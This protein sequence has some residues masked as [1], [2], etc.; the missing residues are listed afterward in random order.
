MVY[1]SKID[2]IF[3][4]LS[5]EINQGFYN[6]KQRFTSVRELAKKCD[7]SVNSANKVLQS[8]EDVGLLTSYPKRGFFVKAQTLQKP[9]FTNQAK[10]IT[11]QPLFCLNEHIKN[12]SESIRS[13]VDNVNH[14]GR[15]RLDLAT[16][17]PDFYPTAKLQTIHNRVARKNP[18]VFT[19][20]AFGV[21]LPELCSQVS[22]QYAKSGC[23]L[24]SSEIVITHGA[25]QALLLAL[26]AT[27][28][29]G[30]WIL[31]EAPTYFGFLQILDTL[32]LNAVELPIDADV[33]LKSESLRSVIEITKKSGKQIRACLVQANHHNPTGLSISL[34]DRAELLKICAD[35]EIAVI[36]DDTFGELHNDSMLYRL[37]PLKALDVIGNVI[38]CS[39]LSKLIAPGLRVGFISGGQWHER[40]KTLQHSISIS[41][42]LLPQKVIAEFMKKSYSLYLKNLRAAC[43]VNIEIAFKIIKNHFPKDTLV[44]KPTGGYLLWVTLPDKVN[45]DLLFHMAL[46]KHG[47]A[48]APGALFS[49]FIGH[50]QSL[51]IN[52]A[53]MSR[54]GEQDGLKKLGALAREMMSD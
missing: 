37:P 13:W 34:E 52:C 9:I 30:D 15:V 22:V 32:K 48:F 11:E 33:G 36:E 45:T 1:M 23:M 3:I 43:Q 50:R 12:R 47:I 54:T 21:G 19:E 39:S 53:L 24:Q 17:S 6:S 25:T 2:A 7:I 49:N 4:Q 38:L 27:T 46:E 42:A 44:N 26:Q 35:N 8:L 29:A 31:V 5:K 18:S 20:Y 14:L 28:S 10:K 16:A 40:I 51:R 41:C